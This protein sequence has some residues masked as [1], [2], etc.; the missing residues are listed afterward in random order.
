MRYRTLSGR[1]RLRRFAV[2][3]ASG[4]E[5]N[6]SLLTFARQEKISAA[7]LT[8]IGAF[9]RATL[10]FFDWEQKDYHR[11]LIEEQVEV[12]SLVGDVTL[13]PNGGPQLHLH[14]VIGKRDGSAHGGHLLAA[15]VRP[16]LEIVVAESPADLRRERDADTGLALIAF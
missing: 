14:V 8:G 3:M 2:L 9:R 10:G 11:I 5:A 12:L 1:D 15:E 13:G 4:D 6:E 7:S 16:T